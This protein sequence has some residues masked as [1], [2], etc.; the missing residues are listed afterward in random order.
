MNTRDLLEAQDAL[1]TA[2][3]SVTHARIN[4]ATA[5]LEFFR[6][7]GLLNVRPDGLWEQ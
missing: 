4:Y 1:L 3:N 2:E 7:I 5:K 6:D